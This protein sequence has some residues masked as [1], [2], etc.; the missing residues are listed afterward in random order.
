MM[1]ERVLIDRD[2][3]FGR[4]WYKYLV[5]GLFKYDDYGLKLFFGVDDVVDIVKR[6]K[7]KV[8]WEYV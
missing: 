3:F 6:V 7:I 2:G 5:Y 8:F 1:V 4:I